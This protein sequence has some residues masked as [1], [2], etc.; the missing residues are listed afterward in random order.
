MLSLVTVLFIQKSWNAERLRPRS[1]TDDYNNNYCKS[2]VLKITVPRNVNFIPF[3]G[4]ST[5]WIYA[6]LRDGCKVVWVI[7][8]SQNLLS[9]LRAPLTSESSSTATSSYLFRGSIK[10]IRRYV[11][12]LFYCLLP[13][14]TVKFKLISSKQ[15]VCYKLATVMFDWLYQLIF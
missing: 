8:Y 7:S 4:H 9:H 13:L 14:S 5:F 15:H 11:Y 12:K 6:P 2:L 10:W 1:T 3:S